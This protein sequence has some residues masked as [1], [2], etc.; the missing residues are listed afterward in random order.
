M[1]T[2]NT[3]LHFDGNC[4]EAFN[5]YKS[6]FDGE[7]NY[8]GRYEEVPE[9]D[10][11]KVPEKDKNKIM[12]VSL[13]IGE[14]ILMGSDNLEAYGNSFVKGDNFSVSITAETK[15]EADRI[16]NSLS[17]NGQVTMPMNDTFWGDYFGM[18][19]DK[20]GIQWMMSY[21]ENQQ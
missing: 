3:Y 14:S 5:F 4:E 2:T 12:H 10:D 9:S 13:P 1:A 11:Y 18:L 19:V 16:F 17:V 21:N 6:V 8:V 7:F 15:E 20:F